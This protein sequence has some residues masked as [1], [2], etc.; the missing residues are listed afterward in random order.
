MK[1]KEIKLKTDVRITFNKQGNIKTIST[2]YDK[3]LT[4]NNPLK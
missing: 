3:D 2:P 4:I 1:T